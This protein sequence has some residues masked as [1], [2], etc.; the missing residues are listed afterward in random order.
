[1]FP[2]DK[3]LFC[4]KGVYWETQTVRKSR[5][6]IFLGDV[7]DILKHW[8]SSGIPKEILQWHSTLHTCWCCMP[9]VNVSYKYAEVC[10]RPSL[11]PAK[12][13]THVWADG[14]SECGRAGSTQAPRAIHFHRPI[15]SGQ[16]VN[17]GMVEQ[18]VHIKWDNSTEMTGDNGGAVRLC[19]REVKVQ[20]GKRL[21]KVDSK[22]EKL[23]SEW[24]S[25]Q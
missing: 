11:Y 4:V 15:V 23:W 20:D 9:T 19:W 8:Q 24:L 21:T 6:G 1:M 22:R 2:K 5:G 14:T 16:K 18:A 25:T 3:D 10:F 7:T 13:V 17:C 12:W